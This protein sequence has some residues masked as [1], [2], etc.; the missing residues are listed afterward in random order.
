MAYLHDRQIAHCDI[1]PSNFLFLDESR[2]SVPKII[3]F[4]M[5][6]CTLLLLF[7][8]FLGNL[9]KF[10]FYLQGFLLYQ[11]RFATAQRK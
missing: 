7:L 1:K 2:E 11:V 9:K 8:S 6:K 10:F 3:D 5:A 4:G